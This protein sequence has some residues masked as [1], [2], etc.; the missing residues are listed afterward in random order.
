MFEM[1]GSLGTLPL[2][3]HVKSRAINAENPRE[4]KEKAVWRQVIWVH[5]EKE[6]HA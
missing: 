6:V 3:K 2:A 5:P 4:K 1:S